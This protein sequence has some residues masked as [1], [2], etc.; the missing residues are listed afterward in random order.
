MQQAYK[1]T[2]ADSALRRLLV[3]W[4]VYQTESEWFKGAANQALLLSLKRL[5]LDVN[6]AFSQGGGCDPEDGPFRTKKADWY[7][8]DEVKEPE[9]KEAE[10]KD[11]VQKDPVEKKSEPKDSA[12][13]ISEPEMIIID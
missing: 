8:E 4:L 3:D 5:S 2:P 6:V 13:M 12:Q 7:D 11:Y 1:H 10:Q 9:V